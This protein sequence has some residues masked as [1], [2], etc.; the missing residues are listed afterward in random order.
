MQPRRRVDKDVPANA[1]QPPVSSIDN[2]VGM[3]PVRSHCAIRLRSRAQLAVDG[4]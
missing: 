3:P 2:A 1:R 4:C